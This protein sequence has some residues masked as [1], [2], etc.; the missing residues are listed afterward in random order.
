MNVVFL[1]KLMA[2]TCKRSRSE[3]TVLKSRVQSDGQTRRTEAIALGALLKRSLRSRKSGSVLSSA[4]WQCA[5]LVFLGELMGI[6]GT[7]CRV[8]RW[9]W[10][11]GGDAVVPGERPTV[12][13]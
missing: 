11:W 10:P 1:S 2:Y 9:W 13:N 5:H 4:Q 12:L 8:R 3:I 6:D 7:T